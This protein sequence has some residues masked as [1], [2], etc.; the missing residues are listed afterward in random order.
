MSGFE[1]LGPRI[2]KQIRKPFHGLFFPLQKLG[3]VDLV[4][5][6]QLGHALFFFQ[7]LENNLDLQISGVVLSNRAHNALKTSLCF[8]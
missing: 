5:G 2:A 1:R 6:S 3:I 7:N 4:V 8:V